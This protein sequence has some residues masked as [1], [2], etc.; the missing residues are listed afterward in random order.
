MRRV[1]VQK[2]VVDEMR[3]QTFLN[4]ANLSNYSLFTVLLHL[5]KAV[6]LLV[7]GKETICAEKH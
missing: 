4:V 5:K 1:L 2:I 6:L 7:S 3:I